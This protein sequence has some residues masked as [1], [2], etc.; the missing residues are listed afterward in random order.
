MDYSL[1]WL[2]SNILNNNENRRDY[3][4]KYIQHSSSEEE[5]S[6][7]ERILLHPYV[8][9]NVCTLLSER[10]LSFSNNPEGLT[11]IIINSNDSYG[12]MLNFISLLR[13]RKKL[14]NPSR[15]ISSKKV[16]KIDDLVHQDF[17]KNQTYHNIKRDL[18]KWKYRTGTPEVGHGE[19]FFPLFGHVDE[20]ETSDI[21]IGKREI[22]LKG[23]GAR[24]RGQKGTIAPVYGL[25][26][27]KRKL[28]FTDSSSFWNFR[29][30]IVK[31][32]NEKHL[33][34]KNKVVVKDALNEAFKTIYNFQP[35]EKII[36]KW[37]D[38]MVNNDGTLS[39]DSLKYVT[40]MQFHYYQ[41]L[42]GFEGILFVHSDHMVYKY[43]TN[44]EEI[45][46]DFDDFLVNSL[47]WS[48][49][50]SRDSV[51]KITLRSV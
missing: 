4:A 11:R 2:E 45:V 10:N 35:L 44:P 3:I 8:H 30:N 22:E 40:A 9:D 26:V 51:N 33:V 16:K 42:S 31:E 48:C 29:E 39:E 46:N 12:E 1:E 7:A 18:M 24:L 50:T 13:D 14:F 19:A 25:N 15:I 49:Y 37:V 38:K 34:K 27:L 17:L 21:R 23:A 36:E 5:V 47:S 41:E 32:L 6:K 43:V 28:E 20:G